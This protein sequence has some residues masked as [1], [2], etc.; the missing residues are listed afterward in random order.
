MKADNKSLGNLAED[1]A[2]EFLVDHGYIILERNYRNNIGEIDIIVLKS[3]SWLQHLISKKILP[4]SKIIFVEV[5]AQSNARFGLAEERIGYFKQQKLR[6]LAAAYLKEKN[7]TQH[8]FR[9]DA[10]RV[11]LSQTSPNIKHIESA[12][13]SN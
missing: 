3:K 6:Q 12:V 2:A 13:E 1:L 5:K 9:I 11:D 10:I 8:S 7:L 4:S